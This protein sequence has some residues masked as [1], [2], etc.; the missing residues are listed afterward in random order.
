MNFHSVIFTA[1][2]YFAINITP[3][4]KWSRSAVC[5]LSAWNERRKNNAQRE[6]LGK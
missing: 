1:T 3:E 4:S 5:C 6:P 2:V